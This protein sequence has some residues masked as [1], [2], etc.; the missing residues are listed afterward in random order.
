MPQAASNPMLE[1][2]QKIEFLPE[3]DTMQNSSMKLK[4]LT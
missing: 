1:K 4:K 3:L 2:T